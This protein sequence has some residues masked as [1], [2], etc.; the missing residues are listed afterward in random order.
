MYRIMA[1]WDGLLGLGG[2]GC[3]ADEKSVDPLLSSDDKTVVS[4]CD[5]V[6][7]AVLVTDVDLFWIPPPSSLKVRVDRSARD[8]GELFS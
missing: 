7:D 6:V 1:L 8:I 3:P 5:R 2:R 4:D